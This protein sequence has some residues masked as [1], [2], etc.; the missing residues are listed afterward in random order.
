MNT[1]ETKKEQRTKRRAAWL[2]PILALSVFLC[3]FLSS[4]AATTDRVVATVTITNVPVSGDT[5]VLESFTRTWGTSSTATTILTNLAGINEAT[6][7]LFDQIAANPY[8][9]G[10]GGPVYINN[11]ETN[12][13]RFTGRSGNTLVIDDETYLSV[14]YVTNSATVATAVRVPYTAE[15]TATTR[16]NIAND[17]VEYIGIAADSWATNAAALANFL[18]VGPGNQDLTAGKV[19]S[20]GIFSNIVAHITSGTLASVVVNG[21]TAT[22]LVNYGNA[23][24][25]PGSAANSEQ[26]GTGSSAVGANSLAIGG[27]TASESSSVAIG[28]SAISKAVNGVA[29]GASADVWT[30]AAGAIAFGNSAVAR[31]NNM[32][33]IG[34]GATGYGLGGISIGAGANIQAGHTN[35]IAIGANV[36]ST[37]TN[38]IM[39]GGAGHKVRIDGQIQPSGIGITNA[40]L[41]GRITNSG[42]YAT[43]ATAITTLADGDNSLVISDEVTFIQLT[44]SLT[45]DSTLDGITNGWDGRSVLVQNKTGYTVAVNNESGLESFPVNRITT[46]TATS[47]DIDNKAFASFVYD[48]VASRWTLAFMYDGSVGGGGGGLAATDIDTSAEIAAIVTDETGSGAL[49]FGTS[50]TITTPTISGAMTLPDNVEQVFNP[51]AANSGLNVGSIAGDPSGP[52]NGAIWYDSTANELTA[53]INGANTVLGAAGSGDSVE[54]DS[55]AVTDPDFVS[56]GDIDFVDTSNTITA[57]INAG[58]IVNA[59]VNASAAIAAS[60]LDS[61]LILATEIDTSAEILAIVGDETGS[62]ALVFGTSPTLTTPTIASFANSTH[63][64]E[65]AAGGGQLDL[66]A[67][68][69]G[70]LPLANGGTGANLSDPGADRIKFWDDSAGAVTW[71][72]AGS[73]LS[74]SGTEITASGGS[75]TMQTNAVDVG[76]A[77]RFN[78]VPGNL[79]TLLA[80]NATGTNALGIGLTG[81]YRTLWLDAGLFKVHSSTTPA[82]SAEYEPSGSDNASLDGWDFDG[83]TDEYVMAKFALTDWDLGTVKAK[84]HWTQDY[85]NSG[86]SVVWGVQLGSQGDSD[87]FGAT[88]GTEQTVT[89]G[90]QTADDLAISSATSAITVGSTPAE[91]DMLIIKVWRRATN[92]SDDFS[93]DDAR[94]LGVQLQYFEQST[95]QSIW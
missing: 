40:T 90:V 95:A 93:M 76:S 47:V 22:N 46:P 62:G 9:S 57:N 19:V 24:S 66:T 60:K 30:N 65:D 59:D 71:L 78:F 20:N 48:A 68:V 37:E 4:S 38:Q 49:V 50:P 80:T 21:I 32:I 10:S 54:I 67:A 26:I 84:V 82:G 14:T 91:G 34:T 44:G 27:A 15:P 72:S 31:T 18:N 16:T 2:L 11:T 88:L 92:G 87:A 75:P 79:I 51:G 70:I 53:R 13:I 83:S 3:S 89:D 86:V 56:S 55:V 81:R 12:V 74:I 42:S 94:L 63:D 36:E 52:A 61:D 73:G 1:L 43:P 6:T 29:I 17:L 35:S 23:I 5:F 33:A 45:V 77:D 85:T 25:S 58:A 7:N 28:Q 69:T 41:T 39:L 64:H 8:A